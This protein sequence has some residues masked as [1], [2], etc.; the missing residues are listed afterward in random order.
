MNAQQKA[1]W[2][3]TLLNEGKSQFL[4]DLML[5]ETPQSRAH[6][7]EFEV[8]APEVKALHA[9]ALLHLKFL[10]HF[11]AASSPVQHEGRL[12]FSYPTEFA[13]W[14]AIGAPGLPDSD[15]DRYINAANSSSQ[16]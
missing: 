13:Q 5:G 2:V 11:G 14:L 3:E 6:E 10:A 1:K 8:S 12:H 16:Q 7:S 15:L 9:A 4:L